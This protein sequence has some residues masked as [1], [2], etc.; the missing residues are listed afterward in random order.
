M[1]IITTKLSHNYSLTPAVR[2]KTRVIFFNNDE[3]SSAYISFP[4]QEMAEKF[5]DA[6]VI[7][8]TKRIK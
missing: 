5:L 7:I 2:H 8:A 3:L 1:K 4:T 6:R